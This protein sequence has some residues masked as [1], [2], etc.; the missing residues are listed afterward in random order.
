[1]KKID[2]IKNERLLE[3]LNEVN[4]SLKAIY[5]EKLKNIILFGSYARETHDS[6]SDIDLMVLI[7][8]EEINLRDYRKRMIELITDISLKYD[9][10]LSI[11]DKNY[12][13]FEKYIK[14]V[15]FYKNVYNEGVKVYGN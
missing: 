2:S 3:L 9:V 13:D 11:V 5:C 15:P 7:D 4:N 6:Q 8:D 1:M 10:L 12:K 14:Y